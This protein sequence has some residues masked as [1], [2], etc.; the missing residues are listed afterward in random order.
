MESILRLGGQGWFLVYGYNPRHGLVC[1]EH[2]YKMAGSLLL[3]IQI[4]EAVRS[5]EARQMH[6]SKTS[7]NA[8][9]VLRL[10]VVVVVGLFPN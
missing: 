9:F 2:L 7:K 1:F 3:R 6:I 10:Q 4:E 5:Y 8:T